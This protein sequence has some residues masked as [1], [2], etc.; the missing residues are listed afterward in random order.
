MRTVSTDSSDS[1]HLGIVGVQAML[2]RIE[3]TEGPILQNTTL[4]SKQISPGHGIRRAEERL[5]RV[6]RM[7]A[8]EQKCAPLKC[9]SPMR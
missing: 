6:L 2:A 9:V 8:G 1:V 3:E 5:E 4:G 7:R